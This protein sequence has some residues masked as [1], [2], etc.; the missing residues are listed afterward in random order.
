MNLNFLKPA[1]DRIRKVY[2]DVA[3]DFFQQAPDMTGQPNER[4]TYTPPWDTS[5]QGT[6]AQG[7]WPSKDP[8]RGGQGL[9]PGTHQEVRGDQT[10]QPQ[11]NQPPGS[12][13]QAFRVLTNHL[14][15]DHAF[16]NAAVLHVN[17]AQNHPTMIKGICERL[18]LPHRNR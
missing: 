6:T 4:P 8:G 13:G 1:W 16:P 12:D 7:S 9:T 18:N 10:P 15:T 17:K 5:P 14:G 3:T 2:A 11:H